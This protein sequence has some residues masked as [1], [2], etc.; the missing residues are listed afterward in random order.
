MQSERGSCTA[1]EA[2]APFPHQV[3]SFCLFGVPRPANVKCMHRLSPRCHLDLCLVRSHRFATL[4]KSPRPV[5]PVS[6]RGSPSPTFHRMSASSPPAR[7]MTEHSGYRSP[8][9]M[10][11]N[12]ATNIR[13]RRSSMTS[14]HAADHSPTTSNVR[15]RRASMPPPTKLSSQQTLSHFDPFVR[16]YKPGSRY[17]GCCGL[18]LT[19]PV[20]WETVPKPSEGELLVMFQSTETVAVHHSFIMPVKR[21]SQ[22]ASGLD[23]ERAAFDRGNLFAAST[24]SEPRDRSYTCKHGMNKLTF[25]FENS[26]G[27]KD[28]WK[29]QSQAN[30]S[31]SSNRSNASS[32]S[33]NSRRGSSR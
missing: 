10:A 22:A 15:A 17:D 2:R 5:M 14:E 16:I 30:F 9:P 26:Q 27:I 21:L 25:G 19:D 1:V 24:V 13:G 4:P 11:S 28:A 12:T 7:P 33:F 8:S 23:E 3:L 31:A 29:S 20:S 6:M 18:L 32:G